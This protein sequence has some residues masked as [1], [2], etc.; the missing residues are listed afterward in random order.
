MASIIS[1]HPLKA[2]EWGWEAH[3]P[4]Y[5]SPNAAPTMQDVVDSTLCE[6]ILSPS[7]ILGPISFTASDDG[8]NAS[9]TFH[10][11]FGQY[12]A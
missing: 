3:E 5:L 12:N 7:N 6:G 10:C 11:C 1:Q 8:G 4:H 2:V 9:I